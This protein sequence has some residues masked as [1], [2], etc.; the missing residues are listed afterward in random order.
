MRSLIGWLAALVA[1]VGSGVQV[2][3]QSHEVRRLHGQ[4]Q[5][6]QRTQD[7]ELAKHSRLLLERAALAAYQN[8]E[9]TAQSELQMQFP[10]TVE[11]VDP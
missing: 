8:V 7:A 4:L 11:R 1:V 9:R 6:A 2:V 5:D 10:L 3:Q